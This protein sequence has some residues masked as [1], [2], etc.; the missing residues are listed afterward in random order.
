MSL[1]PAKT[2]SSKKHGRGRSSTCQFNT[3]NFNMATL[4]RGPDSSSINV[5]QCV[6]SQDIHFVP[7]LQVSTPDETA[8]AIPPTRTLG[9]WK[10]EAFL[11]E[12]LLDRQEQLSRAS[13]RSPGFVIRSSSVLVVRV[14][15]LLL[16]LEA[17]TNPP[18]PPSLASITQSSRPNTIDGV[19]RQT[20]LPPGAY[21]VRM[22]GR[23]W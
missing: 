13:L 15:L 14:P 4:I 8:I 16:Q 3:D 17:P 5:L 6:K 18:S 12:F 19:M 21:F 1:G 20:P 2:Y 11:R 7:R 9:R 22:H 10:E 23:R